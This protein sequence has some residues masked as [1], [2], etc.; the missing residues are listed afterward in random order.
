VALIAGFDT[1][2]VTLD[3][4]EILPYH[5]EGAGESMLLLLHGFN[6]HSGT[7]RKNTPILSAGR[8]VIAPS[9]LPSRSL[10]RE[11]VDRY[12]SQI[13][14]LLTL[15]KVGRTSICGNSMGGWI[16]M[17]IALKDPELIDRLILE[18][19]AGISPPTD[20]STDD[21][22]LSS[23]NRT[24]IP[25]LIIWGWNDDVIPPSIAETIRSSLDSSRLV[26][27]EDAGHVPHW[28][29]PRVFEKAVLHFLDV[30]R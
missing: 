1:A 10:S 2:Y 12:T 7:W 25:T 3:S 13:R 26:M 29:Q 18:D 16:A 14:E 30:P 23:L 20:E 17:K 4:G 15:L 5:D 9:L 24:G 28:E 8:R 21:V 11:K 22:I 27:V 6:A 19:T